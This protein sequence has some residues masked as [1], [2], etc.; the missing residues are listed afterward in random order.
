MVITSVLLSAVVLMNYS[1]SMVQ[2]FTFIILVSTST[3]LVMYLCCALA[4]LKLCWN[5]SLGETGRR[6]SL[7][8]LV[9]MVAAVYSIWTLFGAGEEAFWWSIALFA[10]GLPVY[11]LH[12]ARSRASL[13][14]NSHSD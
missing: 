4:A 3:Y 5:G 11:W 1:R 12:A 9:A 8:L 6:L 2:I 14:V 10:T 7:I 13:A